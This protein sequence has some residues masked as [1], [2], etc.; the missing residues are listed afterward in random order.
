MV[1]PIRPTL[2]WEQGK[3]F[4]RA[5]AELLA[6]TFPER[7]T[8]VMSKSQRKGKIFVDYLRNAEGSTAI[9]AYS[10]R[11]RANA[12]VSTPIE[13]SELGSDVRFDHFNLKTVQARLKKMKKDPWAGFFTTRQA[14]T[15]AMMSRVGYGT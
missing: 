1:L 7:F 10:L 15:K 9:A 5:I 6:A 12:P 14:V 2:D 4:T 11:S 8:A 13:W 3:G